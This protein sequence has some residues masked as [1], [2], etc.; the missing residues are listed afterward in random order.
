MNSLL[1][2]LPLIF[3]ALLISLVGIS[4][5]S[6]SFVNAQSLGCPTVK[7]TSPVEGQKIN[8]I[9]NNSV[10]FT[11]V[12]SD[13]A[14]SN[15]QVSIIMNNVKT[16]NPTIPVGSNDYSSWNFRPNAYH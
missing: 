6:H 4:N 8:N 10:T 7:I 13:S 1:F 3:S 5:F 2:S 9:H 11:G 15:Y 16:Y 14:I 12:S